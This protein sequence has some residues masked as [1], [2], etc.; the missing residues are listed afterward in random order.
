[1]GG[2]IDARSWILDTGFI[3]TVCILIENHISRK[4]KNDEIVKS[5]EIPSSPGGRGQ[6]GG[7]T[8]HG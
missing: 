2:A 3:N 1:M 8:I 6:R 4:V 7:G 5:Q